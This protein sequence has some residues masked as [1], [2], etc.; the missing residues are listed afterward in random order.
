[1]LTLSPTTEAVT[2]K[3]ADGKTLPLA[4]VMDSCDFHGFKCACDGT[5][6]AKDKGFLIDMEQVPAQSLNFKA[7]SG[8]RRAELA[9]ELGPLV[10]TGEQC[11]SLHLRTLQISA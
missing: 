8:Q 5:K 10:C 6:E 3:T 9:V 2:W 1:M 4:D 7:T 11:F